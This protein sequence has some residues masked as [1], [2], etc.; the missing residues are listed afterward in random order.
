M[1]PTRSRD[2]VDRPLGSCPG[3]VS[4]VGRDESDC[5]TGIVEKGSISIKKGGIFLPKER[6][7]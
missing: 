3:Y 2:L 7:I 5:G 4:S 1:Y 6:G